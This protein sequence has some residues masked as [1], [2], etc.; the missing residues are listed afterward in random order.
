[1]SPR[2]ANEEGPTRDPHEEAEETPGS[3]RQELIET[4]LDAPRAILIYVARTRPDHDLFAEL[5]SLC[6]TAGIDVIEELV[7]V[8]ATPS[9]SHY[10]GKG[11]TEELAELVAEVQADLVVAD[12]EL[13]PT[14]ARNLEKALPGIRV[15]DR[16]ELIL[17]I[18]ETNAQSNQARLQVELAR[19]RYELPRLR[20]LWTHLHRERG[21][22]GAMGGM[23][24]KQIEVDRRLLRSR[25]KKLEN[26]L[27]DIE[28]RKQREIDARS[29]EFLVSLVGYT[30]AGKST[31]MNSLTGA[32]V[33]EENRLFSTLDTRTKRWDMGEGRFA[34]L[35]DTVGFIRR[36]PHHLVASFHA[37]LA[38]A[39]DAHLLLLVVDA[40]DPEA[41][42]EVQ[43]VLD[44]LEDIGAGGKEKLVVLNKIDRLPDQGR[45]H[46]LHDK[47]EG[48]LA[49]SA[50]T[51]EGME[52]L[53]DAVLAH[54]DRFSS[55]HWLAIPQDRGD[56]QGQV[57]K[58]A[59]VIETHYTPEHACFK[60]RITDDVL[61]ALQAKGVELLGESPVS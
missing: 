27:R 42:E 23:G 40:S 55:E 8:R 15:V 17:S 21:G 46:Y 50:L 22:I 53:R 5:A 6:D 52:G 54:L 33:L 38:E 12:E 49:V 48:S 45:L 1:M 30:N 19:R 31:I 29:R 4:G 59:T 37:T 56:L 61:A 35:S 24:E 51:G 28:A 14:Q 32:G 20:R 7:Q 10:L 18:F 34:L 25:I 44:V 11:K 13:S 39:L 41:E 9:P 16:S 47:F 36:I 60:V 3:R 26:K 43:T 2:R 58:L 57:R